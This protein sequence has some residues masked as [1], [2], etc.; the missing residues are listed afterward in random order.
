MEVL[1]AVAVVAVAALPILGLLSVAIDSSR[2]AFSSVS[3]ARIGAELIGE[4]QQAS[5]NEAQLWNSREVYYDGDGQ[6]IPDGTAEEA[7]YTA[8]VKIV[9][10]SRA[11]AIMGASISSANPYLRH[12]LVGVSSKPGTL[13]SEELQEVLSKPHERNRGVE[14]YRAVLVNTEK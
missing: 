6:R 4:I 7:V 3:K 1:V 9:V 13:G 11:G 14:F 2:S 5:W 8:R 10:S 12:V